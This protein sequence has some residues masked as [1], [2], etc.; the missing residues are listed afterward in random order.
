MRKNQFFVKV[1]FKSSKNIVKEQ[2]SYLET[3]K[4]ILNFDRSAK[5][6]F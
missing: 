2:K 3:T 6:L 1:M 5:D 4:I